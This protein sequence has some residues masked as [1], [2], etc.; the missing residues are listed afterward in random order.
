MKMLKMKTAIICLATGFIWASNAKAATINAADCSSSSVTTAINKAANGDTVV[1]PAGT[2]TW[3]SN[4]SISTKAITVLGAGVGN[5]VINSGA[6]TLADSGSRISGF[7]FNIGTSSGFLIT[8]ASRGFRIDHNT[9]TRSSYDVWFMAY[10]QFGTNRPKG[11][12]DNNNITKGRILFYGEDTSTG[13]RYAWASPLGMGTDDAIYVEDNTITY[14]DGSGGNYLN[15]SDCNMGG[16]LV[17]RFNNIIGGRFESHSLQGDN[18]RGC[19]LFE[20]YNNTLTNPTIPNYRPFFIRGGTGVIFHNTTDGKFVTNNIDIDNVRSSEA[21]MYSGMSWG[22]CDGT[23][24]IDGSEGAG[25]LC[26]DQIGTGSD[27][28]L[29]NY[30]NTAPA[31]AKVPAY[32]WKNTR[33]DTGAELNVYLQCSDGIAADCANQSKQ[34][35]LNR[36]YFTYAASFDGTSGVGEGTLANRPATCTKGVGY[37]ANDQGNWNS[38]NSSND[39]QLYQCTATNTWSLYYTPYSYPHLLQAGGGTVNSPTTLNPPSNLKVQ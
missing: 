29:W 23:S 33:T 2:C 14:P 11:L 28:S 37:W 9:I 5:T 10:G 25:Y 39:G 31:Q 32:F 34:I 35:V 22:K 17:I 15:S 26:R 3:S 30:S 36:D 4:I 19:M 20:Y 8:G 12:I 21:S 7:T 1:V 24:S 38:K 16:K 13:G 27:A 6:F 18:Q